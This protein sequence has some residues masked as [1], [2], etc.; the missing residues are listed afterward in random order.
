MRRTRFTTIENG[1]AYLV[2]VK[3]SACPCV[4]PVSGFNL[5]LGTK[6]ERSMLHSGMNIFGSLRPEQARYSDSLKNLDW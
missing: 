4:T 6:L 2:S 1:S 5:W 3:P